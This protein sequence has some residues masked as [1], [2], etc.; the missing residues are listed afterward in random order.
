[1]NDTT[2]NECEAI[3]KTP[4]EN[5]PVVSIDTTD[6][7][8]KLIGIYG[9]Q[10]KIKPEKWYVGQ[11]VDVDYRW[12]QYAKLNVR[13]QPKLKRAL[14]KYGYDA[15]EKVILEECADEKETLDQREDYWIVQKD[16]IKNGYNCRR[17]GSRGR[18]SDETRKLLSEI[19]K[20]RTYSVATRQKMSAT[21]T[22]MK[23]SE[24]SKQKRREKLSGENNPMFGKVVTTERREHQSKMLKGRF[25]GELHP[26]YGK[27]WSAEVRRRM[28]EAHRKPSTSTTPT[29]KSIG[30][31]ETESNET[32]P[33]PIG[34]T[35]V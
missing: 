1:M 4:K 11:S 13:S 24:T 14:L 2:N 28:S 31:I 10:N 29:D 27:H 22:G 33:S 3:G 12:S 21:R 7:K 35:A 5:V 26:N 32:I 25:C 8:K 20:K 19:A 30:P 15:F 6:G 9:L 34:S 17:G 18:H 23:H 16:S